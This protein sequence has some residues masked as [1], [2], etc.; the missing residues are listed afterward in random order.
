MRRNRDRPN[1][2]DS[3]RLREI[4]IA[5]ERQRERRSGKD[6]RKRSLAMEWKILSREVGAAIR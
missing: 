4:E 1:K 2:I 5:R 6:G 3:D